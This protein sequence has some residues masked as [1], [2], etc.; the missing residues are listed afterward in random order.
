MGM[1]AVG[2]KNL[3]LVGMGI[4]NIIAMKTEW[5]RYKSIIHN[6]II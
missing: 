3:A 5:E 2:I 6:A 4:Y 1:G